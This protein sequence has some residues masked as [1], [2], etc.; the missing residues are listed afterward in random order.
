MEFVPTDRD[1]FHFINYLFVKNLV[2]VMQI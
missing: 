2:L 1:S